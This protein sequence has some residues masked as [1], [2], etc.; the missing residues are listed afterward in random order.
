MD[1]GVGD[2]V[3]ALKR[4]GLWE[5]TILVMIIFTFKLKLGSLR[6]L[7]PGARG[8]QYAWDLNKVLGY[9]THFSRF[10]SF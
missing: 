6:P 3:A 10:S 4:R 2:L 9:T 8:A 7:D 1:S 5:N